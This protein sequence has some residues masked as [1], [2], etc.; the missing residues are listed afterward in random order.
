MKCFKCQFEN[1]EGKKFC[2]ECGSKLILICSNCK[3]E[4]LPSGKFC[5]DCGKQL[6]EATQKE[7]SIS[8]SE[9]ERKYVTVLFSDMSG[10]TAMTE[11]IDPEEVKEIMGKVFGEISQVVAKYEGFIEKFVG[12]AVMA[13]FGV[14]KSHEDDPVRAI[15]AAGEIHDI[16]LSI[17]VHFEKQIEKRLVMHTGIC[18]GL[19]VTGEVNLE[20]G[21]HG[22]L[23]ETI[24][25]ASRLSG[26]AAPGEIVVGSDTKSQTEGYFEF[27][28]LEP[29]IIKGKVEPVRPYKVLS[30]KAQPSKTHRLSG[31]RAE[32]TGR[33]VEISQLQEALI[34][35]RQGKGTIFSVIGDAGTGKSRLIEEFKKSID[36]NEIQWHEAHAYA[37]AQNIPYFPFVDLLSRAWHIQNGD[38]LEQVTQKVET[39]ANLFLGTRKDLVPYLASLYS[40]K[41]LNI[42]K[43]SPDFLKTKLHESIK[44]I[45]ESFANKIS[46]IICVEDLHW[47]DP[48]SIE[49][50]RNILTDLNCPLM[51]ICIYRPPFSLFSGHQVNI[52]KSYHEIRLQDLSPSDAQNMVESL[53]NTVAI[54]VE[55]K[56]FIRDKAEGNPFYLEEMINSIIE[57]GILVREGSKWKTTKPLSE[58]NLPSNV[59]GVI[60]AR[61]DRLG[62]ESKK[63]LQEASVIGRAFLYEVLKQITELKEYIDRGLILLEHLD[64]VRARTIQPDLEYI[65]KHALTQEVVYNGL[66]KKERQNIHERIGRVMEEFFHNRLPEFY[67]DLAYH[68]KRSNNYDKSYQ[69]LK[70]SGQKAAASNS[71]SEAFAFFNDALKNFNKFPI[72]DQN[73]VEKLNILILL[74]DCMY[75]LAYPEGSLEILEN[76]KKLSEERVDIRNKVIFQRHIGYLYGTRGQ[77]LLAIKYLMA[78]LDDIKKLNDFD[79]AIQATTELCILYARAGQFQEIVN[80]A[81]EIINTAKY[82]EKE[83]SLKNKSAIAYARLLSIYGV[84]LGLIGDF[85]NALKTLNQSIISAKNT[86]DLFV[87]SSCEW[88]YGFCLIFKGDSDAAIE[89]FN[90]SIKSCEKAK[91]A[92]MIGWIYSTLGFAYFLKDDFDNAKQHAEHGLN[93]Q[94]NSKVEAFLSIPHWVLSEIYLATGYLEKAHSHIQSALQFAKKNNERSYESLSSITEGRVYF[95]FKTQ[96]LEVSKNCILRG[97][98]IAEELKLKSHCGIGYFRIGE[99][100]FQQ[101]QQEDALKNLRI[102]QEMFKEMEMNYWLNKTQSILDACS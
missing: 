89:H 67:E 3:A 63:I 58:A 81:P 19:V 10:F 5:G 80:I 7:K 45:F 55:L 41:H 16:V 42:K 35:L 97:I 20:H 11:K 90:N 82:R 27:E 93:L 52:L 74:S 88:H 34:N 70:L 18:T 22:V 56:K 23:G 71:Y 59:Q 40:L 65:F 17:S 6:E 43:V 64:F 51:Y 102:A 60:S 12:D 75:T 68:Y 95:K 79:L 39:G 8:T 14:P 44:F 94:N 33:N 30:I 21:T 91:W 92:W 86:S 9:S 72:T 25:V 50:L 29:T 15:R 53:L 31:I 61:L 100:F 1:P 47:A 101:R 85:S 84:G 48:S 36:I 24:N 83:N 99:L 66:L 73:L 69:Y 4:N 78:C 57:S 38:T 46:T 28:P 26:L 49:L 77:H 37:Y 76:G 2:Q 13:L 32:L 98:S 62:I 96:P 87:L 54:P